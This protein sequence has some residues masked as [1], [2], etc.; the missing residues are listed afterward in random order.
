MPHQKYPFTYSGLLQRKF[1]GALLHEY[2]FGSLESKPIMLNI[3]KN[4]TVDPD[5][6]NH[7]LPL[8]HSFDSCKKMI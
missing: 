6:L 8:L 5:H 2:I 3:I 4:T 7:F 1:S